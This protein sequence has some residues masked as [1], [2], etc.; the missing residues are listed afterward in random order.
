MLNRTGWAAA[1]ALAVAVGCGGPNHEA[2]TTTAAKD[3][4]QGPDRGCH[5]CKVT[6]GGQVRLGEQTFQFQIEAIPESGPAAGPGFGG[7][8]VAAKGHLRF[9][10]LPANLDLQV[11]GAVDT[12]VRCWRENGVL[13]SEISGTI[14]HPANG[15]ARFTAIAIDRGEP[16]DD[17]IQLVTSVWVVP[18]LEV[19]NGN[20]QVHGLAACEAECPEEWCLCPEDRL[21]CEPCHPQDPQHVPTQYQ[22]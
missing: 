17:S 13:F 20:V 9:Q 21:T 14:T 15:S 2:V 4:H 12:I 10:L 6:G 7:V 11:E 8:G 16:E 22:Y 3:E 18:T 5:E 19:S 1:V